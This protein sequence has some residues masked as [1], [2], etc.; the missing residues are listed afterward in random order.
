M[1]YLCL[2]NCF[3]N[4]RFYTEGQTYELG[5]G[6][7]NSPKNFRLI[8]SE[9]TKPAETEAKQTSGA[10]EINSPKPQGVKP[11]VIPS[12]MFWCPNCKVLHRESSKL[13]TRHLK[14]KEVSSA[15]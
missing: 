14:Y 5:E 8:E 4:G 15:I 6:Q 12:G 3:V 10:E 11:D 9:D 2:R 7:M 13:G 1:M